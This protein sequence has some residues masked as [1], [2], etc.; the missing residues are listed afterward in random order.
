MPVADKALFEA[1]EIGNIG[2]CFTLADQCIFYRALIGKPQAHT[3]DKHLVVGDSQMFEYR[4][5]ILNPR[6][7]SARMQTETSRR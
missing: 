1:R 6:G 5:L 4:A 7:L 2:Q 3:R